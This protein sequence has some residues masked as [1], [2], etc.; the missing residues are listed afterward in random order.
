MDL[1][2]TFCVIGKDATNKIIFVSEIFDNKASALKCHFEYY[3]KM[4]KHVGTNLKR[5]GYFKDNF[6]LETKTGEIYKAQIN[7]F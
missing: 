3:K 7:K 1:E 2:K 5:R 4:K 6:F